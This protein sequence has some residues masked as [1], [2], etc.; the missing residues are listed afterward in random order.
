VLNG[1]EHLWWSHYLSVNRLLSSFFSDII[2]TNTETIYS[3][4]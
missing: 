1:A 3:S 4:F 2:L